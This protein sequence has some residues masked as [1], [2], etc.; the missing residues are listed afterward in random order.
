M[1]VFIPF[2]KVHRAFSEL[3]HLSDAECERYVRDAWA[4]SPVWLGRLPR[5]LT[6]LAS[7]MWFSGWPAGY[8][9]LPVRRFIPLPTS[10]EGVLIVYVV[11]GVLV[12]GLTWLLVRDA[13]LWWGIRREVRRS[14]CPKCG[15]SLTGLPIRTVGL[16]NDPANRFVRCPECGRE[17]CLLDIGVTPRDL[18]P[19]EQRGADPRIGRLR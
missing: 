17:F 3:D 6:V 7:I 9:W 16:G 5:T 10:T 14:N 2:R 18:V 4:N 15:Q 8:T 11:S 1:A 19:F 12:S 13:A